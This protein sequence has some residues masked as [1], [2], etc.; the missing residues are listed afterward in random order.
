M[1]YLN[2]REEERT[3]KENEMIPGMT[4]LNETMDSSFEHLMQ[5]H[6]YKVYRLCYWLVKDRTAAEDITQEVFL[7]AYKHLSTFRGD[8]R[9]E[10]WLYRI[11]VNE[12]KRYVRSWLFRNIFYFAQPVDK[13]IIDTE[14]Q[15]IRKDELANL[16]LLI[17]KLPFRHR[18]I[19]I[20]HYYEE[21]SIET[22]SEILG[23][24]TGA[25][26]TRLHRAREQI[27]TLISKE[28]EIWM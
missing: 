17:D 7:R 28:G 9:I 11:A 27:K 16:A 25:V 18:Q 13:G 2:Y 4:L 22:I 20:L 6:L 19:L 1:L 5:A 14:S 12:S 24:S 21:L 15:V 10:T 8:S 3:L 26:Y 23:I